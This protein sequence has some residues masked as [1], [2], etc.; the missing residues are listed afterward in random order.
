VG[1]EARTG[2]TRLVFYGV[3]AC[4]LWGLATLALSIVRP[5]LRMWP[6]PEPGTQRHTLA[7]ITMPLGPLASAGLFAVG[8][9]DWNGLALDPWLRFAAGGC[10]MAPGGLFALWG[11][12][13]LG[14]HASVGVE[15]DLKAT[16]AY[17]Y[18][19]N[20]QYVGSTIGMLG[21]ALI[22]GSALALVVWALWCVWF[23]LAPFAEEPWLREKLGAPYD[24]Y[25]RRVRRYV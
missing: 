4:Q 9:L 17:R 1:E 20:P 25:T 13:G 21:Y 2:V 8:A 5:D 16:G 24:D 10:L 19:R 18:S 22:C 15:R 23:A 11:Y 14:T 6:P 12:F 3:V 7:R